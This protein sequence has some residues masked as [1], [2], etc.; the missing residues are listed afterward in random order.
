FMRQA[1]ILQLAG[2]RNDQSY[3]KL[4]ALV[5]RLNPELRRQFLGSTFVSNSG[6]LNMAAQENIP[7]LSTDVVL[8]TLEDINSSR[9]S[10]P[11]VIMGMLQRLGR[12][13]ESR[14]QPAVGEVND[15][16]DDIGKK[17]HTIFREHASEEFVPDEYQE[18]LN[19]I[20]AA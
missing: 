1:D 16:D 20:M 17:M 12:N 9:L 8:E 13:S 18:K 14:P 10:V 11:P 7:R 4:A 19:R 5:A 2:S 6:D 3:E 15:N